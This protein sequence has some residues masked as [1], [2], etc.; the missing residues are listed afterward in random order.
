MSQNLDKVKKKFYDIINSAKAKGIKNDLLKKLETHISDLLEKKNIND[1]RKVKLINLLLEKTKLSSFIEEEIKLKN[2]LEI[3][4]RYKTN[5]KNTLKIFA[6]YKT[7][8]NKGE[9]KIKLKVM[10]LI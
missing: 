5:L 1:E 2:T 3:V 4:D 9:G 6:N 10:K 7:N 8:N